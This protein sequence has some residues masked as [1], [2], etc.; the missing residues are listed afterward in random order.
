[1]FIYE[2][3]YILLYKS[4]PETNMRNKIAKLKQ[5]TNLLKRNNKH[6]GQRDCTNTVLFSFVCSREKRNISPFRVPLTRISREHE[7]EL[8]F[9]KEIIIDCYT[10][11]SV[12]QQLLQKSS[13]LQRWL[14]HI[15]SKSAHYDLAF[16][17][18][19]PTA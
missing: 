14:L 10:L 11:F 6:I 16:W 19:S 9:L 8:I 12:L 17:K 5:L 2:K 3:E 15:I 1:M 13:I 4:Y 18:V 7:T